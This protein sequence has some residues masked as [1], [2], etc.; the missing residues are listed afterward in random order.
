[1]SILSE[2]MSVRVSDS[3]TGV[4]D[5]VRYHVGSSGRGVMLP[6][7]HYST[8]LIARVLSVSGEVVK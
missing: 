5:T 1:M 8:V 4:T 3:G 6:S 7:S 2:C